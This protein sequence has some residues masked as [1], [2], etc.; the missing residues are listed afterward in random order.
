MPREVNAAPEVACHPLAPL[1]DE[2]AARISRRPAYARPLASGKARGSAV[3]EAMARARACLGALARPR[4]A[5][6]RLGPAGL[7]RLPPLP[8]PPGRPAVVA[9][10]LMTLG[11]GQTEALAWLGGDYLAHHVQSE[12]S[13]EVL[14]ALGRQL[15]RAGLEAVPAGWST[16]KLALLGAAEEGGPRRW[17]GAAV[18]RLLGAFGAA[19]LGVQAMASGCF[20][21]LHTLLS[22]T[23][24]TAATAADS[25]APDAARAA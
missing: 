13:R 14:F 4:S 11:H 1:L 23:L 10:C 16:R 24:A 17:D 3:A 21:P 18:G 6:L 5:T 7:A 9:A 15:R 2:A 20:A 22:L 8:L 25:K 19:D 12:L